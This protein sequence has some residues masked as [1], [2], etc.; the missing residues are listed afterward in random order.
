MVGVGACVWATATCGTCHLVTQCTFAALPRMHCWYLLV[1]LPAQCRQILHCCLQPLSIPTI[2]PCLLLRLQSIHPI[3]LQPYGA[4]LWRPDSDDLPLTWS[5]S[6]SEVCRQLGQ[7][8]YATSASSGGQP[9]A[10]EGAHGPRLPRHLII[11]ECKQP[12]AFG[13]VTGVRRRLP[14][15]RHQICRMFPLGCPT[16]VTHEPL[17]VSVCAACICSVLRAAASPA[18]LC[19]AVLYCAVL[20]C[21]TPR[22][23]PCAHRVATLCAAGCGIDGYR[24]TGTATSAAAPEHSTRWAALAIMEQWEAGHRASAGAASPHLYEIHPTP[25]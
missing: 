11:A 10:Q 22:Y 9:G 1:E 20:C 16:A 12:G 21:R 17:A 5:D 2:S 7:R 13:A 25:T 18:V 15:Q 24:V 14:S 23:P 3:L 4:P 6:D 19:C 8:C